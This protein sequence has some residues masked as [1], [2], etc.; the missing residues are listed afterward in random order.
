MLD[1]AVDV[2]DL[3]YITDDHTPSTRLNLVFRLEVSTF[4]AKPDAVGGQSGDTQPHVMIQP[5]QIGQREIAGVASEPNELK[6]LG[7]SVRL[8]GACD[9]ERNA[10]RLKGER[11]TEFGVAKFDVAAMDDAGHEPELVPEVVP[12]KIA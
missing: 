9:I 8:I 6:A 2:E 3:G 10:P 12:R 11:G 7:H 1:D 5:K 4:E